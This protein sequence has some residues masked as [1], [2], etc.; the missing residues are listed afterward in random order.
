MPIHATDA[1]VLRTYPLGES[2]RLVVFLTRDQGKKRG[3]ARGA[4]RSRRRFGGALE[5]L[6]RVRLAYF[7]KEHR[8]LVVLDYAEPVQ[9]PLLSSD[10]EALSQA[11]YFAELLDAWAP[12]DH[13]N[14]RLFRL[15]AAAVGAMARGVPPGLLARYFEYWLLRLEGVYP[16]LDV[17]ARCGKPLEAIGAQLAADADA[18]ICLGCAPRAE[19]DL[20]PTGLAFL[21][22]AARQPPETVPPDALPE[23]AGRELE[24]L[25]GALLA[26]HLER[27]PRSRRVT[28]EISA[29][30]A[31]A[32][33]RA[34]ADVD[35]RVPFALP[36]G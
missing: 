27:E 19:A 13:P 9:S 36:A 30:L 7:E 29:G 24:R 26:R 1:I 11:T 21:R 6:T 31:R 34:G 12:Q 28:R 14:E 15:G 20:S 25:H 4:R 17:C 5:P 16:A 10:V 8:E 18:L 2:D 35:G 32:A 33:E 3:V 22:L 23:R